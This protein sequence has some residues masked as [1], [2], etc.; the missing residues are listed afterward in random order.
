MSSPIWTRLRRALNVPELR[1]I[2]LDSTETSTRRRHLVKNDRTKRYAFE[3]WYALLAAS[4]RNVPEG[5]K[6]EIGAGGGFLDEFI[7]GLHR[8][9][10]VELPFLDGVCH[11]E[12]MPYAANEISAFLMIN[13]LHHIADPRA[14][15]RESIRCL[16]PGGRIAMI[17]PTVTPL[18]RFVYKY[19][20]HEPF[21]P[22]ATTWELPPAG[23]LSGGNDALPWI[24]HFRDQATFGQEFPEL[25][26]V[27]RRRMDSLVHILSGGVTT[28][29][30]VPL[31]LLKALHSLEV[32][33]Q[34]S[35]PW[36]GLFQFVILEKR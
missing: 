1:G 10:V 29:A 3:L 26:F 6:V 20:H 11:A 28:R 33:A 34:G 30:L 36:F 19:L 17:E 24:I 9:D 21:D 2:D 16:Q 8:T 31:G 32:M 25:R 35:M 4:V 23:R 12:H 13:V 14:F 22:R 7:P 18:S 5:I 27:E 15:F